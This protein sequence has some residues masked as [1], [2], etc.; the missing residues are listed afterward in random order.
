MLAKSSEIHGSEEWF[1][2]QR[3]GLER[4]ESKAHVSFRKDVWMFLHKAAQT[5][6]ENCC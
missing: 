1:R 4:E 3:F 6:E 2:H 5:D